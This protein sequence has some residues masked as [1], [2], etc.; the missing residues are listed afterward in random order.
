[1]NTED[2]GLSAQDTARLRREL[3]EGEQV[4][5]V[6]KPRSQM[7]LLDTLFHLCRLTNK[8]ASF[9]GVVYFGGMEGKRTH[10]AGRQHAV[11]VLF[12]AEC[13]SRIVYDFES[14]LVCNALQSFGI[15][16][17]TVY[18]HGHNGYGALG[19]AGFHCF[20]IK[21]TPHGVYVCKNGG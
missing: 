15:A 6:A 4:V 7:S 20:R 1:M 11:P 5:L 13:V 14:I 18:V 21:I 3:K 16:W 12:Y 19:N 9:Y 8:G 10:I 2:W 17:V